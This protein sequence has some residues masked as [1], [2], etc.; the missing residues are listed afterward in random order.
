VAEKPKQGTSLY[1]RAFTCGLVY[2]QDH[3]HVC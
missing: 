2:I 3:L 1:T